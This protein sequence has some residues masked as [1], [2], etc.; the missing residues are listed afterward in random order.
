VPLTCPLDGDVDTVGARV[1]DHL[2]AR[3]L[4]TTS[5]TAVIVNVSPDLDRGAAN[6]VRIRRA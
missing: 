2:K 5:P 3:G 4:L 1:V 6:F